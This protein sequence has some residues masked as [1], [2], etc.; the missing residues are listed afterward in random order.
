MTKSLSSAG[1]KVRNAAIERS[2]SMYFDGLSMCVCAASSLEVSKSNCQWWSGLVSGKVNSTDSWCAFMSNKIVS[3]TMGS[4]RSSRW[5]I[6]SPAS[7]IPKHLTKPPQS[8]SLISSP[9]GVN[10][11][12]SRIPLPRSCRPWKKRRRLKTGC[13]FQIW[14]IFWQNVRNFFCS[15]SSFQ[16]SQASS[17]SWQ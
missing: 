7:R 9:A 12:R 4:P 2:F 17:L 6:R 15:S 5:P 10:Q 1:G 8:L 16:L 3:P 13:S 11:V 14:V